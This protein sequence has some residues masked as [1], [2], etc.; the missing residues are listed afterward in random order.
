MS[1]A[2]VLQ[3]FFVQFFLHTFSINVNIWGAVVVV[4]VEGW[5][6]NGNE[7]SKTFKT[8]PNPEFSN[9]SCTIVG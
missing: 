3:L 4:V 9:N 8:A 5:E 2:F 1:K 7:M 6:R